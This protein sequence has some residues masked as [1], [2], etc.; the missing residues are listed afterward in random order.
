MTEGNADYTIA[1]TIIASALILSGVIWVASSNVSSSIS[2]LKSSLQTLGS[3]TGSVVA[4]TAVPIQAPE[5]RQ[6][7]STQGTAVKGNADAPVEIIEFSDFQ[8]PFCRSFYVDTYKQV[9]RDYVDT[10]KAVIYFKHFP[11]DQIHPGATP[12][13][14]AA[15]C[16][17][18]QGKFWELHD[19]IFD[20]QQK[21]GSGT[22]AFTKDDLKNWA[23]TVT[24]LNAQTFN[25]CL[26]SGE[27]LSIVQQQQTQG[28]QAGVDG[29][30]TFFVNGLKLVGAQPYS[31]F[32]QLIDAELAG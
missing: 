3:G 21:Q 22:V 32:K 1:I 24:G 18:D 27:K 23:K 25:A 28:L 17:R 29:T 9:L 2:D 4:P 15:E 11:L 5:G 10:G 26:D 13:A 8:C 6:T 7:I 19:K 16:A 14:E 31:A 20:E 30:P 12:A